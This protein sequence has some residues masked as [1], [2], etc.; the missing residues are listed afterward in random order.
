MPF[1]VANLLPPPNDL[2]LPIVK[3]M[4]HPI[5]RRFQ[6]NIAALSLIPQVIIKYLPPS[7]DVATPPTPSI[8]VASPIDPSKQQ[9]EWKRRIKMYCEL[10]CHLGYTN[11]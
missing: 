5:Y 11:S 3:L 6:S 9:K 8:L 7:W 10:I 2:E 4:N 1:L